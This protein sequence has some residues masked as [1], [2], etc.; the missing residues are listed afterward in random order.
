MRR[1]FKACLV[2]M[3]TATLLILGFGTTPLFAQNGGA[4]TFNSF[5]ATSDCIKSS[6]GAN[7]VLNANDVSLPQVGCGDKGGS[8]LTTLL[9]TLFGVMAILSLIFVVL[10][11]FKYT[12]SG[13]SPDAIA[14]AKKTIIYALLGL[15]L[16][17]S[18]F[19]ITQ[20]VLGAVSS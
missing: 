18:A 16:G 9:S 13:G 6:G 2:S 11:A 15:L 8:W 7:P 3:T 20:I 14:S 10:G 17:V 4:A 5:G 1:F 12:T 19:T